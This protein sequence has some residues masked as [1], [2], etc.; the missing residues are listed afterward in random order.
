MFSQ[1]PSKNLYLS[2]WLILLSIITFAMIVVGG[3]TRLTDSGLSMVDWRPIMGTLPPLNTEDWVNAF[4]AYKDSPEFK[5][6]NKSMNLNEFKYIFWWEWGHRFLARCLGIVFILPFLYF[7]FK[8]Q[9]T[10]NTFFNLSFV[11]MF[12]IFQAVVGWWM[13]KSGL[14]DN[15]YVSQYRLAF[16]LTNAI[17]ILVILFWITLNS[18]F[19]LKI[20]FLPDSIVEKI[21]LWIIALLF[22]T[23]ISGAFMAGTNAGQSFN[24]YPLM[25]G[26]FI[27]D[28]YFMEGMGMLNLF[29][30]TIAINFNHRWL[31]TITFV[32]IITL[33][34]YFFIT[35]KYHKF[36][37]E[38]I[39]ISILVCV[40]F[41]LGIL[42]LLTNV[43]LYLASMH[44]INSIILLISMIF[45]YFQIKKEKFSIDKIN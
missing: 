27:P 14:N 7:I 28:D 32:I 23:I 44:Q 11:F 6:I 43:E 1:E 18:F 13:V 39:V 21:I 4:N 5:I 35:K 25:N 15:P 10:K 36:F 2:I 8:K 33:L 38:L 40:Q 31:A 19:L 20:N 45:V 22:L 29:E 12:G 34:S 26:K 30:N 37:Y 17:I 41:L 42:T 16:H 9:I 24:T 3:L